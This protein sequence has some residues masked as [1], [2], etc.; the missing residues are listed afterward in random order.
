M[1]KKCGRNSYSF[2]I[3]QFPEEEMKLRLYYQIYT[4][5]TPLAEVIKSQGQNNEALDELKTYVSRCM[6][7]GSLSKDDIKASRE[8]IAALINA[9]ENATFIE[10]L[11]SLKASFDLAPAIS[12]AAAIGKNFPKASVN[13]QE[14]ST[15]VNQPDPPGR[16]S[17]N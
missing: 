16:T 6:L 8:M 10:S 14:Q 17:S 2:M 13:P 1:E 12:Q 5:K 4:L 7:N 11:R 3:A 15:R 9:K